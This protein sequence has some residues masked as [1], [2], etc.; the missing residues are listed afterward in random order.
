MK[1][2]MYK[3]PWKKRKNQNNNGIYAE[4]KSIPF[5]QIHDNEK[6]LFFVDD[7]RW[8]F[9]DII[10]WTNIFVQEFP[11]IKFCILPLS[12]FKSAPKIIGKEYSMLNNILKRCVE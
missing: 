11:N 1:N 10:K 7:D 12:M 9:E 3:R 6:L 4:Y 2:N 8:K 5:M